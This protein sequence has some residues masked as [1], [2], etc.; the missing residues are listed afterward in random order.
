[1][2]VSDMAVDM[3]K[4][5]H[6]KSMVFAA[7][8]VLGVAACGSVPQGTNTAASGVPASQGRAG[9]SLVSWG[10]ANGL[11]TREPLDLPCY[12]AGSEGGGQ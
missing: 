7:L 4:V 5:K 2:A 1:M 9:I 8:A 12:C 10:I 3:K 11:L 6:M